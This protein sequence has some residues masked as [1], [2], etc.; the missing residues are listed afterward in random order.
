MHAISGGVV[1]SGGVDQSVNQWGIDNSNPPSVPPTPTTTN[2][3]VFANVNNKST[4]RDETFSVWAVC[5]NGAVT[6]DVFPPPS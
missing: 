5:I 3:E 2:N 1:D 6:G 4:T